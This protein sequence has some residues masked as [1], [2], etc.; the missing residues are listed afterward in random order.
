MAQQR[1][2][3]PQEMADIA[4]YLDKQVTRP[5]RVPAGDVAARAGL[6]GVGAMLVTGG[7]AWLMQ[8]PWEYAAQICGLSFMFTAGASIWW[9][10]PT[11]KR[12]SAARFRRMMQTCELERSKKVMAYAAIQR[13]EVKV[14]ETEQAL[15]RA[16][17][18]R[19]EAMLEKTQAQNQA[20]SA[21]NRNFVRASNTAAQA[22]AQEMLRYWGESGGERWYSRAIANTHGWSD[23]RHK[24]AQQLLVDC[25]VLVINE[26]RPKMMVDSFDVALRQLSE[27]VERVNS[28]SV[29][30]TQA[31][32]WG[33]ED[34]D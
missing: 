15:N 18:E 20:Q 25:G 2:Y 4:S 23:K 8:M 3:T 32:T 22:D 17:R 28:V 9:I 10:M 27:Y 11:D 24:A 19:E 34:D 21:N 33:G 6:L 14:A 7:A 29:G 16:I 5:E 30:D 31:N 13:L 26:K 1:T 12:E